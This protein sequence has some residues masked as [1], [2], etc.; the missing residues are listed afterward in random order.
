MT[1]PSR[2]EGSGV[3]MPRMRPCAVE[4]TGTVCCADEELRHETRKRR[5]SKGMDRR[6]ERRVGVLLGLSS[7]MVCVFGEGS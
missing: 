6:G 4:M 1:G 5:K 2:S 3:R 7:D